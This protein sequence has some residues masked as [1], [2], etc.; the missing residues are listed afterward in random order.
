MISETAPDGAAKQA[1]LLAGD[2]VVSFDG[3]PVTGVDDLHRA[4][5]Q[6]GAGTPVPLGFSAGLNY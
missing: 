2:V 1:G 5:T 4:L 3:T 6:E